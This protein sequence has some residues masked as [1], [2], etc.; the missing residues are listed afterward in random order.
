MDPVFAYINVRF[1]FETFDEELIVSIAALPD[2]VEV[3]SMY[4]DDPALYNIYLVT[5]GREDVDTVLGRI[6]N[7]SEVEFAEETKE[8]EP[9]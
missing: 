4:P 6:R 1:N 7:F 3:R 8:P 2:V 5:T 9:R